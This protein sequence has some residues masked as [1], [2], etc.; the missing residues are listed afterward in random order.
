MQDY[1]LPAIPEDFVDGWM[2]QAIYNDGTHLNEI[3]D[4]K[5]LNYFK[6]IDQD[7]LIAFILRPVRPELPQFAVQLLGDKRL[8]FFRRRSLISR[9]SATGLEESQRGQTYHV[10]G[11][12]TTQNGSNV[13]GLLFITEDGNSVITDDPNAA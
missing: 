11:Y 7:R 2:W 9:P 8:V 6:D 5:T 13:K 3:N 10:L 1:V 12:Q 4:D